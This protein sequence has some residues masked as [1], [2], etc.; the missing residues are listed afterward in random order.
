MEKLPE[1]LRRGKKNRKITK[2][3]EEFV[4]FGVNLRVENPQGIFAEKK[5][6]LCYV[7]ERKQPANC[8]LSFVFT[9][10]TLIYYLH[11]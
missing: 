2:I 1:N 7:L 3:V 8:Q 9:L 10:R 11:I 4:R 5:W 6:N